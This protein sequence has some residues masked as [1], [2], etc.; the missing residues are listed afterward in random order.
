MP[1]TIYAVEEHTGRTVFVAVTDRD[2][3]WT[4]QHRH[5][6]PAH[7]RELLDGL[8][9]PV[10]RTLEH[11]E[12]SAEAK[13]ARARWCRR[14]MPELF[15]VPHKPVVLCTGT[16]HLGEPCQ[17][18]A[19]RDG[20]G[21]CQFHTN[22]PIP[23]RS[24]DIKHWPTQYTR[25][26]LTDGERTTIMNLAPLHGVAPSSSRPSYDPPSSLPVDCRTE[27]VPVTDPVPGDV[28]VAA[29]RWRTRTRSRGSR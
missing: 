5:H 22:P 29:I 13:G 16:T 25:T 23:R 2:P 21:R 14:L 12:S 19:L 10:V 7:Q 18:R 15:A 4:V 1:R 28:V 24:R 26:Q 3:E 9:D 6:L 11:V 17:V 20:S 27:P 8:A